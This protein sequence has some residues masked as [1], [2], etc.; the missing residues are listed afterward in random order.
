MVD[1]SQGIWAA[2]EYGFTRVSPYLPYRSFG[3][4]PGL[5]GNLLCATSFMEKFMLERRSDFIVL[6]AKM[7]MMKLFIMLMSEAPPPNEETGRW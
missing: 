2:H 6:N 3:H 4:Y 1:K 7:C 5:A